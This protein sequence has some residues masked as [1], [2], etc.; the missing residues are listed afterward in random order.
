M[1]WHLLV[2]L[3]QH[4]H[5]LVSCRSQCDVALL[6]VLVCTAFLLLFCVRLRQCYDLLFQ[7]SHFQ[8]F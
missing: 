2:T 1:V 5:T 6:W 7:L 3:C 8:L 4:L